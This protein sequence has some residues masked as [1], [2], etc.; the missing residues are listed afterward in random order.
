MKAKNLLALAIKDIQD[1]G[2]KQNKSL[3]NV[4]LFAPIVIEKLRLAL[5]SSQRKLWDE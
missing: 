4:F 2:K 3:I 5:R 1:L